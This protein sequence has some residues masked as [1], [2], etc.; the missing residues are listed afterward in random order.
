[1]TDNFDSQTFKIRDAASYD[2]LTEQFDGFTEQLLRPLARRMVE[3]AGIS[4]AEK[5]LDI[6]TGTGIVALEA[7]RMIDNSGKI[8]GI[9]LSQE[10]LAK[11][12]EKARRLK[13]EQKIIFRSMDAEALKFKNQTFD[14][15]VS[16]FA[17]LHFPDPLIAL[18]EIFRVLRPG[19][20]LVLAVGSGVPFFSRFGWLHI[21]K[22]I[23]DALQ[24]LQGKLLV[25]PH[26]LDNFVNQHIPKTVEPDESHLASRYRSRAKSVKK[27][28]EQAGFDILKTDWRGHCAVIETPEKFWDIQRTFSR[29]ARKRLSTVSP[30]RLE[31]LHDLF[32]EECRAAQA[33][34]ARLI[35]PFGAF[36]VVAYRRKN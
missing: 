18:R 13:I 12:T 19:G 23:P 29:V 5:I 2:S 9:D 36:Y 24:N 16:L 21:L 3:L 10:M 17:L 28:I 31:F 15:A 6:G 8:Y 32:L 27:L 20:R 25:A 22:K 30:D 34:G 4:A 35:Y 1:M 7:A 11:A 14:A 33:R 26:F